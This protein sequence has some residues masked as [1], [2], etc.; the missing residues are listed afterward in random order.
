MILLKHPKLIIYRFNLDPE[1]INSDKELWEALTI[2]QMDEVVRKMT[3][4]LGKDF[5]SRSKE[6]LY[7]LLRGDNYMLLAQR[8]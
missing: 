1:G 7:T 2:A 8:P 4:G 5:N 3:G 6:L